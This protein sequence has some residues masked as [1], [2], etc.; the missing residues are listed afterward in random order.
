M[1]YVLCLF[2]SRSLTAL[3]L[4]SNRL[5]QLPESICRLKTLKVLWLDHN[6]IAGNSSPECPEYTHRGTDE[7]SVTCYS[8]IVRL[9]FPCMHGHRHVEIVKHNCCGFIK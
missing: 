7:T 3:H 8:F 9:S 2:S 1:L 6:F 4:A 5:N